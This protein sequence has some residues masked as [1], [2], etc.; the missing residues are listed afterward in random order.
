[1][2]GAAF[3]FDTVPPIATRVLIL[4]LTSALL[5][6]LGWMAPREGRLAR[7]LLFA[8]A[9][10][11]LLAVNIG[12]SPVLPAWRLGPPAWAAAV[13]PSAKRFYVSRASRGLPTDDDIDLS[14]VQLRPPQGL[15]VI[16]GR[17]V[18]GATLAFTPAAWG[19][20]ELLSYDLTE[21]WPIEHARAVNRFARA[22]RAGR[23]RFLARGGVRYCLLGSPPRP[24]LPPIQFVGESFGTLAVYDC[25]P[26]A[27][28]VYVVAAATVIPDLDAQLARLFDESFA[29]GST[30]MLEQPAPDSSGLPR[31]PGRAS[32]R[33]TSDGDDQVTI[34][35]TADAPGGFLVLLDSFDRNWR[36][37]VDGQPAPLLRANALYRAVRIAP[38][39]HEVRF[40][41]RPMQLYVSSAVSGLAALM[42][43]A[44][45]FKRPRHR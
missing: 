18:M 17:T 31:V 12:L 20:R 35:A 2:A 45:A 29:D 15:N 44:L 1:V 37:E 3:L 24:G 40:T 33:I 26:D 23:F 13:G 38:G 14:S 11:E 28:R 30:I 22:D 27:R 9:T 39:D 5:A 34:D 10:V 43:I 36:V 25:I 8:L 16:E 7:S 19:I 6:Y 4:L 32:A 21:L 42:V 41:F